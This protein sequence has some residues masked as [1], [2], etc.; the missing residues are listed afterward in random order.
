M[1]SVSFYLF[2]FVISKADCCA[3]TFPIFQ[4]PLRSNTNH[5][6]KQHAHSASMPASASALFLDPREKEVRNQT[7]HLLQRQHTAVSSDSEASSESGQ[8]FDETVS[9]T[10]K[11][12]HWIRLWLTVKP[13]SVGELVVLH[14]INIHTAR[15]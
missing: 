3:R 13:S 7:D 1:H 2:V 9:L 6:N 10:D 5:V 4:I 8:R 15:D 11:L 14:R 12:I